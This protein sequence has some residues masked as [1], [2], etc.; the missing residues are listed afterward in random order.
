MA[1]R[2]IIAGGSGLI[3]S[4]LARH[5]AD[6]K[7]D[8]IVLT[9][10]KGRTSRG[11]QFVNWDPEDPKDLHELLNNAHIVIG[12]SG[13]SV[14]SRYTKAR[15]WEIMHS[16]LASTW[17]IGDAI[18]KCEHPPQL[19]LQ[20]GTATIYRHAEDRPMDQFTGEPGKGFSVE[21][22]RTWEAA[23]KRSIEGCETRL[24][25]LRMAMVL[26]NA[27]GV[28][29]KLQQ[30][31]RMGLG[32]KHASGEQFVS[33]IHEKDLV[34]AIEHIMS[35]KT[36]GIYDLAAPEPVKDRL[37]M[38]MLRAQLRPWI[39]FP[40]PRWMLEIGAWLMRTET[41]LILKSRRVVP[42][43]L[44]NEGFEF[45]YPGIST[46]LVDLMRKQQS[47]TLAQR[48]LTSPQVLR[49]ENL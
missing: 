28:L 36:E 24:V 9:R 41:E 45:R 22:A 19:W 31:V 11:I 23:A 6:R 10:G 43:R 20:A 15:K 44:L 17:A 1:R 26:S 32:G 34:R 21:V 18:G 16:R 2:I 35:S 42:T 29:P 3:G 14:D 48:S 7:D 25:L 13:A 47:A 12:L 40:K 33:W 46:A 30:I 8:V 4:L 38:E 39:S 27:G 5:F 49:H 37:L